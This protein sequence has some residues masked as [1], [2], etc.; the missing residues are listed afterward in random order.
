MIRMSKQNSVWPGNIRGLE[1]HLDNTS[2]VQTMAD[3]LVILELLQTF[4]LDPAS[5]E[6]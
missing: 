5:S 3:Q 4:E 6:P 2:G 1:M